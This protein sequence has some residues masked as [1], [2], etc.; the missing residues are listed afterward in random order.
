MK[1][2]AKALIPIFGIIFLGDFLNSLDASIVNV[3]L[4]TIMESFKGFGGSDG[5]WLIFGYALGLSALILPFNKFSKNGRTRRFCVWGT[6]LFAITSVLCGL[7]P[8]FIELIIFRIAQGVASAMIAA[9]VPTLIVRMIPDDM[10][11][12]GI[13]VTGAATGSALVIGPTL[14]GIIAQ[15]LDWAWLFYINIPLCAVLLYLCCRHLP[16]DQGAD[17]SK[18]PSVVGTVS[19]LLFFACLLALVEDFGDQDLNFTAKFVLGNT[20]V[21]SALALVYCARRDSQRAVL[22]TKMVMNRDF[23]LVTVTLLLSTMVAGGMNYMIPFLMQLGWGMSS[24]ES[25]LYLVISSVAMIACV[26]F[27]GRWCDRSGC[28]NPV[29]VA[30]IARIALCGLGF[31]LDPSVGIIVLAATLVIL[32]IGHAFSGTAQPTRM[33]HHATPGYEDESTGLMLVVYYFA[34]AAGCALFA[35]VYG[36]TTGGVESA[37]N[38]VR[39]FW[40]VSAV[41]MAIIIICL[42][43]TF[44]VKNKVVRKRDEQEENH[45]FVERPRSPLCRQSEDGDRSKRMP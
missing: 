8:G 12:L 13:A 23:M 15:Y 29:V 28:R 2:V 6:V 26:F 32:G 3:A 14:G 34:V 38:V 9:S 40:N 5:S 21:I 36:L 17:R 43:M 19:S 1:G 7:A 35:M 44:M 22:A 24:A 25:G 20:A 4:P 31:F 39:A 37:D 18:D 16:R 42:I 41:G 30:M 10:K 27:V 45:P 11:G 33:I